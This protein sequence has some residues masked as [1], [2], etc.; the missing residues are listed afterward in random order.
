MD[1]DGVLTDGTFVLDANG[2]E[3]KRFCFFDVMGV[4]IGRAAGLS[5]GVISGENTAT[6]QAIVKKLKIEHAYLGVKQKDIALHDFSKVT[7]IP[8]ENICY[9]GD[10]INDIPAIIIAGFSAAPA[11]GHPS[12]LERVTHRLNKPGGSGALR[13]LIEHLIEKNHLSP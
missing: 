4:S 13:E 5:F 9:I 8:L 10:D 3:S 7:R 2:T 6:A 12:V 11:N 1:I